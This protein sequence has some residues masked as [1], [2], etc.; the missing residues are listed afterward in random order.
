MSAGEVRYVPRVKLWD[1]DGRGPYIVLE[2]VCG[3]AVPY[4]G[5]PELIDQSLCECGRVYERVAP[6][7][8]PVR[9]FT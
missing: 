5:H 7:Q 2:C 6:D 8:L 9:T 3:L 1:E 4:P